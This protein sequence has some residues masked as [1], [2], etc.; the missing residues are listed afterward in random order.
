[1]SEHKTI[2][3]IVT[4]EIISGA[5]TKHPFSKAE[6]YAEIVKCKDGIYRYIDE[7]SES[8]RWNRE[9]AQHL[10]KMAE[11]YAKN[12][13]LAALD[14][15]L[16]HQKMELERAYKEGY[17]AKELEDRLRFADLH[18]H[19]SEPQRI[20]AAWVKQRGSTHP[21]A[22]IEEAA[23]INGYLIAKQEK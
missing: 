3:N 10:H 1:M 8:D 20:A 6:Q 22:L 4:G 21:L 14:S 12:V 13:D 19:G 18:S 16:N 5:I 11:L 7:V 15:Y 23:F 2:V 9:E 17:Q